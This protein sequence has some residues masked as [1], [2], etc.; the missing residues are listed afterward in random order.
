MEKYEILDLFKYFLKIQGD[1]T[2]KVI[3]ISS[4]DFEIPGF[5]KIYI[6]PLTI[7]EICKN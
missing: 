2:K 6:T 3:I 1:G 5:K 4:V 7:K